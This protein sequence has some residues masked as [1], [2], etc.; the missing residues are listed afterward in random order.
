MRPPSSSASGLGGG[1]HFLRGTSST[2]IS[3]EVVCSYLRAKRMLQI[4]SCEGERY[5]VEAKMCAI[6]QLSWDPRT[7]DSWCAWPSAPCWQTGSSPTQSF[8]A[9][10]LS[11]RPPLQRPSD[12]LACC[13]SRGRPPFDGG[14]GTPGRVVAADCVIRFVLDDEMTHDAEPRSLKQRTQRVTRGPRRAS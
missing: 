11:G 9:Q 4:V 10:G 3:G 8:C 6:D 14:G 5:R 7:P 12:R 1:C 13:A 2:G